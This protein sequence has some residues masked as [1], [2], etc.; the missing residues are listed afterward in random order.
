MNTP[1]YLDAAK[2]K[3]GI[4]SDYALAPRLELSRAAISKL[5]TGIAIMSNTTAA[6][7]AEILELDLVKVIADAELE[8]GT[9]DELWMRIAKKVAAVAVFAIGASITPAPADAAASALPS[10]LRIPVYYVKSLL[11]LIAR[12][13]SLPGFAE[14][15]LRA[16]TW[17]TVPTC[18]NF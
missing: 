18:E 12:L 2:K 3:L 14:S 10:S 16:P 9:N 7:L 5:R 15:L 4:T 13:F 11:R 1:Q 6:K 17:S 8:R